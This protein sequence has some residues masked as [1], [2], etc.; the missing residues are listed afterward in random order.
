MCGRYHRGSDK[1]RIAEAFALGNLEGLAL[2]LDLTP[3]YNV[4]PQT[5][6]PVIIWDFGSCRHH[7]GCQ[8]LARESVR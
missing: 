5:M 1:Q 7:R 3:N 8:P 6:Q 2:E 4:P